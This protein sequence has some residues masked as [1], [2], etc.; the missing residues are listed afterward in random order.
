M[1]RALLIV[2]VQNDFCPGGSLATARG[3]E[4]A[5]AIARLLAD[6]E[7]VGAYSHVVATQDWH[8]DPGAHFSDEPDFVDSWPV[9]CVAG[10]EGAE[11]RPPLNPEAVCR[12]FRKGAYTAA[13]SGFEGTDETATL[14]ADWLRA[15]G[16]DA[17]DV[18]GIATDHCV[19]ATVLDAR[20]EGFATRVLAD[21][22][23]PVDEARAAAAFE[24][25][26][27]AGAQLT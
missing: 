15:N 18:C 20:A 26:Q 10:S 19:R 6:P 21:L 24:E 11:L 13:Y 27:A 12:F 22:C 3:D 16:V 4:V 7:Q 25:M 14:L 9:H 2:D 23:A 1:T 17:L 8:I 5:V